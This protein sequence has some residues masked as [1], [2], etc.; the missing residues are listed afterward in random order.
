[1]SALVKNKH[2]YKVR[3]EIRILLVLLSPALQ[4][5]GIDQ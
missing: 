5:L 4:L 2:V 1:M 3:Y